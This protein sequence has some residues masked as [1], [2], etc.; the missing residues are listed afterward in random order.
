MNRLA[1]LVGNS[2]PMVSLR[3]QIDQLLHRE[4]T[5]RRLPPLLIQGET[6]TGKGLL[7]RTIHRASLRAERP[8]IDV[9]CAAI[10][11]TLLEAELFGFERGAF[12]DARQAKPGLFQAAHQ[13][14]IFLDEV[15]TLPYGLQAKLLTVIEERSV[16]RLGSTRSEA[17]DAWIMAATNEDLETAVHQGRF[18]SDLYHRLAALILWLPP[19]RDRGD[20]VILLAEQI[21]NRVCAA[22]AIGRKSLAPD[23]RAA[24]LARRWPGNVRELANTIERAALLSDGPIVTA[25]ML[26]KQSPPSETQPQSAGLEAPVKPADERERAEALRLAAALRA[27]GGNISRAAEHLGIPR[28]SLRYRLAKLGLGPVDSRLAQNRRPDPAS[29]SVQQTEAGEPASAGAQRSGAEAAPAGHSGSRASIDIRA[30]SLPV[31]ATSLIGRRREVQAVRNVLLRSDVRLLTLTGPG[32]IG[33]TRLAVQVASELR[34][35]FDDG[36]VFVGFASLSD[37]ALVAS[38]IAQ[39][40]GVRESGGRSLI[41]SLKDYLR[42]KTL[43]LLLDNVERVL[44]AGPLLAELLAAAPATKMLLTSRAVLHVYGEHDFPVPPLDVPDKHAAGTPTDVTRYDAVQ[45]FVDRARAASP[46][47]GLASDTAPVVATICQH[48]EGLPLALELAARRIR[49]LSPHAI[50]K[51]IEHRL[52]LLTGGPRDLPARQQTLR[53]AIAW[54]YDLLEVSEQRLFQRLSVFTGGCTL[55]AAYAVCAAPGDLEDDLLDELGSLVDKSLL[56]RDQSAADEPR[57]KMLETLREYAVEKLEASG[58]AAE[59]RRR[60]A[61]YY[62]ALAERADSMLKG[63][64]QGV[65]LDRLEREHDNLRVVL[66]SAVSEAGG[67]QFALLVSA[68]MWRFWLMRG[69]FTEGRRWLEKSLAESRE[70]TP[71][72]RAK[73]LLAVGHLTHYQGDSERAMAALEQ[74]AALYRRLG[75]YRG[76]ASATRILGHVVLDRGDRVLATAL[77]EESLASAHLAKDSWCVAAALY[78]LGSVARFQCDYARAQVLL[79]DSLRLGRELQDAWRIALALYSLANVARGQGDWE[80]AQTQAAESLQLSEQL[81]DKRGIAWSLSNLA[82]VAWARGSHERAVR[83][84]AA[85]AD[86]RDAVGTSMMVTDQAEYDRQL[87]DARLRLGEPAFAAAWA[88]GRAMTIE[89]ASAYARNVAPAAAIAHR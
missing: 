50:L 24:L 11:E 39:V 1:E 76:I 81:G 9:N 56:H 75:D 47:F 82:A 70:E 19:L 14:T 44:G 22:Y 38:A 4:A 28:N 36:V 2:S 58:E 52:T 64:N 89:H 30:A 72:S 54:S 48:L 42:S 16:R 27:A 8:F 41:D 40:L 13:G 83:L 15:A 61:E 17:V 60:H 37:S 87:A 46:D 84:F 78:W 18:R 35:V 71:E 74:S 68:A 66:A 31:P 43:L 55:A 21:L 29:S 73:C 65:W 86:L 77:F 20:D 79:T 51:R 6:G 63:Q 32:G 12:T 10:P 25:A 62:L 57:F 69:Y 88:E 85:A 80:R 23:T 67:Q 26:E 59:I 34:D 7:A 3:K 49:L 53:N 5:S 33:K 45:L